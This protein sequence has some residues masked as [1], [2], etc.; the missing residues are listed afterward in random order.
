MASRSRFAPL[1]LLLATTVLAGEPA[2]EWT[3][4]G[5]DIG[6]V[7]RFA[8]L[9]PG[10][11]IYAGTWGG[12]MFRSD[13]GGHTWVDISGNLR[14]VVV[15]DIEI[16]FDGIYQDVYVG[17]EDAGLFR[18][19]SLFTD[20]WT[21]VNS[22]LG[23]GVPLPIRGVAVNPLDKRVVT[24]ATFRGVAT[25]RTR[26]NSWP[27]SLYWLPGNS[28][29]DVEASPLAPNRLYALDSFGLWR[30]ED[31]GQTRVE[32][33]EGLFGSF[34]WDLELSPT[35]LDSMVVV[36][37]DEGVYR[38]MDGGQRWD[39]AGPVP[40]ADAVSQPRLYDVEFVPGSN[41]LYLGGERELYHSD[42]FGESW[43][44]VDPGLTGFNRE[45][46]AILVDDPQTQE[47][48]LGS[49]TWGVVHTGPGGGGWTF[50]NEGL[51]AAWV[52]DVEAW[53]DEVLAVTQHGTVHHS[54]DGG[55]TWTDRTGGLRI[56]QAKDILRD[57]A[58]GRWVLA[59]ARGMWVTDNQGQ[60]WRRPAQWGGS[61]LI[62]Y[63][64]QA[65]WDGRIYAATSEGLW[66]SPDGDTWA[67]EDSVD[68]DDPAFAVATAPGDQSVWVGSRGDT[69][70]AV[71]T[72][73]GDFQSLVLNGILP[74]T[75]T[76]FAFPDGTS[77]EVMVA[78]NAGLFALVRAPDNSYDV[79]DTG[80]GLPGPDGPPA[81]W[82][83]ELDPVS[84]DLYAGVLDA[85]V[86]RSVDDGESWSPFNEGLA[87]PS[88]D[89]LT[90]RAEPRPRLVLGTSGRGVYTRDLTTG[91]SVLLTR[92]QVSW[93]GAAVRIDVRRT[94]PG[95]LELWRSV[96]LGGW[97]RL[98]T[99]D[100]VL[101][102]SWFDALDG[103]DRASGPELRYE[104][105]VVQDGELV[106][107]SGASLRLAPDRPLTTARLLPNVP[108]PFNPRTTLRLELPARTDVRVTVLDVK[109][110]VV[111]ELFDGSL[112]PGEHRFP[113]WGED[114]RR[115][116]VPSGVYFARVVAGDRILTGR[117]TLVR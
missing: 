14:G 64:A 3:G 1:L 93:E 42:D 38:T 82:D 44:V 91:V 59:S 31:R 30:T 34:R 106:A 65:P 84:G 29:E 92:P 33:S 81:V 68:P 97:E 85:G 107:A 47:L 32:L 110:R 114:R 16:A 109:G 60:H 22:G 62:H 45:V 96:D 25:S 108:N 49:S 101:E 70:V 40:G 50:H 55:V 9:A 78:T 94:T 87:W 36:S 103:V 8:R 100:T 23:V 83:V 6:W 43:S 18:A 111:V 79:F 74:T 58:T 117:M 105:R 116:P 13:D 46:N 88:C 28:F 24:V 51:R 71:S 2:S 77:S 53:D 72:A 27:D 39:L 76:D 10:T 115:R 37:L 61:Q 99:W 48:I 5:P 75:V 41:H 19:E 73:G 26:G 98:W 54:A 7:T 89:A 112:G 57:P 21:P 12:G 11:S 102:A 66:S 104:V 20:R 52:L 86:F 15:R 4:G 69:G 80:Q 35:H 67:R 56:V 90:I 63:L 95:P 113:W 17:T